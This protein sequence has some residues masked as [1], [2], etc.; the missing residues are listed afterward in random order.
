LYNLIG[1]I[2][3]KL[4]VIE[5]AKRPTE[6]KNKCK[7]WL[8]KCECGNTKIASTSSLKNGRTRSCGC[9]YPKFPDLIGKRFG[10]WTVIEETEKPKDRKSSANYFLCKCDC[11]NERVVN[12]NSLIRGRS[13]S[14]GCLQKEIAHNVQMIDLTGNRYGR[15][16]VLHL[17]NIHD[18]R[19][20]WYCKCDCGVEKVISGNSLQSGSTLSCG[21]YQ[22][23]I[24]GNVKRIEKGMAAF[25][26]IFG[27]YKRNAKRR[28]VV[29][30]LDLDTFFKMT[31]DECHYC[32]ELPSQ[33]M[34]GDCIKNGEFIY[35]GIDRIDSNKGYTLDNVVTCCKYCNFGK[36][37][38]PQQEF[39]EWVQRVNNNLVAKGLIE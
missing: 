27:R 3:G 20:Y 7:Y 36:R 28:Q 4:T 38:M 15:L 17:D 9:L 31:Q 22:K 10:R 18:N 19:T 25:N 6:Y 29:F 34:R 33:I 12:G 30:E 14:C 35:N 8:C 1:K 13:K 32:G 2:F 26:A 11:G 5:E 21:C 39:F 37:E 23:E 16:I 24:T